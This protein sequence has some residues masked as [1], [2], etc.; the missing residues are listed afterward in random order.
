MKIENYQFNRSSFLSV[1]KDMSIIVDKMLSNERLKKLLFYT[2]KDA[3]KKPNLS[4]EETLSLFGKQ[5]KIV[6]KLYV[7]PNI[8]A[9]INIIF[10]NFVPNGTNP[11]FRDNIISFDIVCHHDQ[12]QLQD[13]QLRPYRIAAEID[14]MLDK[15]HL[16]GIGK[17]YFLGGKRLIINDEFSGFSIDYAAIHGNEDKINALSP[18]EE[19]IL[20]EENE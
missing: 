6:P 19:K 18:E 8:Q 4:E 20:F 17:L 1:E 12:W 9:Y 5:I 10:D 15:K 7:D 14:Q 16:T 3:Y 13:F 2:T 11:E